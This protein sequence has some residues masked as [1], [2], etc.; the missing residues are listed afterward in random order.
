MH[1]RVPVAAI[2][3]LLVALGG[4]QAEAVSHHE[5]VEVTPMKSKGEVVG[6]RIKLTL[7]PENGQTTVRIGL[8]PKGGLARASDFREKASG[9]TPYLLHQFKEMRNLTDRQP[10]EVTLTVKYADAPNLVPGKEVE[11]ISAWNAPSYGSYW[12]VYGA[13]T[14]LTP[15][16]GNLI[17]LPA[18]KAPA[19]STSAR[20]TLR[21]SGT[22]SRTSRSTPSASSSRSSGGTT[23][24]TTARGRARGR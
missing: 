3:F 23:R 13:R 15:S 7:R 22:R 9:E 24:G 10:K 11:V 5:R 19:S 12:H 16:G 2:L 1:L 18:A 20:Q 21:A 6:L 4:R 14:T 8:G 17:K